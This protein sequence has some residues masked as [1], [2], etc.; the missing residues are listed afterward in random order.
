VGGDEYLFCECR[1]LRC[2]VALRELR[3]V[4]PVLP[5]A[6]P[7][8]FSPPWLLGVCS[9][10]TELVG[11]V[12]P[13]ALLLPTGDAARAPYD[14]TAPAEPPA[15]TATLIVGEDE[16]LLGLAV[17]GLGAITAIAPDQIG[18]LPIGGGPAAG[19]PFV[20]GWYTPAAGEASRAV[21]DLPA[22]VAALLLAL[23]EEAGDG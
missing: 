22:L 20:R 6:V 13:A 23:A 4:L 17:A 11:L 2:A 8:P 14:P 15:L 12:D 16:R 5:A 9:V 19:A 3:E 18:T 1:Q 10:R 21:L 7:L